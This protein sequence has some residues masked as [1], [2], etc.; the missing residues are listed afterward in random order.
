[1]SKLQGKVALVTGSGRGIGRAVALKLA[2]EGA[3]LVIND[4]DLEPAQ[5]VVGGAG[6]DRVRHTAGPAHVVQ[7]AFPAVLEPDPE[8]ARV[9]PHVGATRSGTVRA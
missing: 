4:L 3:K 1:M 7:R 5:A 9:Q 6:G 8:A 2:S